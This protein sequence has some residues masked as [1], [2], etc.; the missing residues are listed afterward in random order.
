V[1]GHPSPSVVHYSFV[2]LAEGKMATRKGNVVLLE[3]FMKEAAAKAARQIAQKHESVDECK[4][5]SIGY[6]AVKYA[7][8]RAS[9]EKNVIFD[10]DT[11][12]SFEG[13][14][15]PYLQYSL[16]RINSILRKYGK[17]L[18]PT[19]NWQVFSENTEL[20]LAKELANFPG[21]VKIALVELSPHVIA[22]YVYGLAKKFS[23]FYHDCPV[24]QADNEELTAA[25]IALITC[26]QQVIRNCFTLLGIEPVDEM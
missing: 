8:L 25:R 24:L 18:P 2:L 21:V 17:A 22:N 1:L 26:V 3:D 16:V 10:W 20:D 13:D 14:S 23:T 9:N 15:G 11:A 12:L 7:I 19:I 5:K 4:A 6:G